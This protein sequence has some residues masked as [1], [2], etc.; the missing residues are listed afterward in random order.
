M[1]IFGIL[2]KLI[3]L[4]NSIFLIGLS[5]VA[6]F[7]SPVYFWPISFLGLLFPIK[8]IVN[9]IFLIYWST[10]MKKQ[11]W[12]NLIILLIGINMLTDLLVQKSDDRNIEKNVKVYIM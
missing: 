12:A 8:Y 11:L 5:Y 3:F 7:L 2:N 10:Q 4:I 9:F 1:K 6:Q